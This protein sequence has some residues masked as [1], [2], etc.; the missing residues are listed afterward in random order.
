MDK[1]LD[2]WGCPGQHWNFIKFLSKYDKVLV[3]RGEVGRRS[4]T[5]LLNFFIIFIFVVVFLPWLLFRY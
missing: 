5:S 4:V 1:N 3:G 2:V